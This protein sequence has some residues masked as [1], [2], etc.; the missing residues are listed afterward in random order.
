MPHHTPDDLRQ[1]IDTHRAL[2]GGFTML[3]DNNSAPEAPKEPSDGS[4]APEAPKDDDKADKADEKLGDSGLRALQRERDGRKAL[5]QQMSELKRGLAAIAGAET[6]DP[7]K[8]TVEDVAAQMQHMQHELAVERAAR[9]HGITAED[10]I[11][12][13]VATTSEDQLNALAARLAPADHTGSD[14]AK[15]RG[16]KPDP[17]IGRGGGDYNKGGTVQAGRDAY[18]QLHQKKE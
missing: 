7:T 11:K 15:P 16:P 17:S 4:K 14:G 2:F 6:P 5:E 12:L 3:A 18:R 10:D 1:I 13:L 9:S 8:V